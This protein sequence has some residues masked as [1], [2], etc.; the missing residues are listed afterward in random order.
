MYLLPNFYP[1][2]LCTGNKLSM[3]LFSFQAPKRVGMWYI[4]HAA[5]N[6]IRTFASQS[7]SGAARS[8]TSWTL[9]CRVCCCLACHCWVG[10]LIKKKYQKIVDELVYAYMLIIPLQFSLYHVQL[11]LYAIVPLL[12]S[13]FAVICFGGFLFFGVFF[14]LEVWKMRKLLLL[15]LL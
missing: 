15:L 3:E 7:T 14:L 6:R 9:W 12:Q 8:T 10:R 2:K 1:I 5:Q 4:T 13:I 11:F